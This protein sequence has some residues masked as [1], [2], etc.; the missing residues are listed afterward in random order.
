VEKEEDE[1][2]MSL[3]KITEITD[4]AACAVWS[5]LS[6]GLL[7]LGSKVRFSSCVFGNNGTGDI[8]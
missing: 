4:K 7:A 3:T 8:A 2:V 5:P 6:V 1:Q